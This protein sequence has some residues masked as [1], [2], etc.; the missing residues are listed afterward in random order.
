MMS[1][2]LYNRRRLPRG[3]RNNNPGNIRFTRTLW[4]GLADPPSDGEFCRFRSA[5][6]GLRA[7]FLVLFTYKRRGLVTVPSIIGAWAPPHENDTQ[8]YIDM[9]LA[10]TGFQ[11]S[12]HIDV[13]DPRMAIP[14]AR[15]IV[16]HENGPSP[17][18][19][20]YPFGLYESAHALA[21]STIKNR[22][23]KP[24]EKTS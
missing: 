5:E 20:W 18:G 4:K 9:V 8:V 21:V 3:I 13:S 2:P 23:L 15:A 11:F 7:L 12:E 1:E 24:K 16:A 6:Y 17:N 14:M 22:S 19:P 10:G